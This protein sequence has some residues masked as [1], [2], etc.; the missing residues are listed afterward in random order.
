MPPREGH[1]AATKNRTRAPVCQL[2]PNFAER[3]ARKLP[4]VGVE[5]TRPCGHWIL[6][7][8]R[9]PFRH[10]GRWKQISLVQAA[11]QVKRHRARASCGPMGGAR[12]ALGQVARHA[13][14]AA[15]ERPS[16]LWPCGRA[17]SLLG[18][19]DEFVEFLFCPCQL[20]AEPIHFRAQPCNLA[21]MALHYPSPTGT[22]WTQCLL[23]LRHG[24][25][26]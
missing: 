15:P 13:C 2:R 14:V 11:P 4:E 7:P 16:I 9:L 12:A 22:S 1:A 21:G 6:S 3:T 25:R 10:S 18:G 5:P 23:F 26:A 8:A 19:L 17:M 20:C 24:G